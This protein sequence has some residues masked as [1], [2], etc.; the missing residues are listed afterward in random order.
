MRKWIQLLW[1]LGVTATAFSAGKVYLV[2]GSDTGIWGGAGINTFSNTYNP[3]LYLDPDDNAYGIMDPVFR[4]EIR[5]SRGQR[6]K[7]TWWM[8]GGNMFRYA[9]NP[10]VPLPNTQ[11]LY[12]MK[13]YHGEAIT[14]YGDELTLHYHTWN[15]TDYDG[16]GIYWWNQTPTFAECREDFDVTLA[17]YLLEED[18]FPVSYRSG[19]HF[20]DNGWQRYLDELLP[21]SMHNAYPVKH[22]D[23]EEPIDNSGLDWS[24]ATPDFVP[25]HP[26]YENYQLPG[27]C[28]GWNLR[29]VYFKGVTDNKLETIF[30]QAEN[31]I[32]QVPC[33][34]SHLPE[35][36]F[37]DQIRQV[38]ERVHVVAA[39]HPDVEFYYMTAIEAMQAWLGTTDTTAPLVDFTAIESGDMVRLKVQVHEAIFQPNP[40]VA[41]K[42]IYETA[43]LIPCHKV[44]RF[45]WESETEFLKAELAKASMAVTDLSG[46]LTTKHLNFL[47]DDLYLDNSDP[48]FATHLGQWQLTEDAAWGTDAV[49]A[50]LVVGDSAVVSWQLPVTVPAYYALYYQPALENQDG[51]TLQVEIKQ[52]RRILVERTIE[53]ALPG[54][55]WHY[56]GTTNLDPDRSPYVVL[57][58]RNQSGG[59]ANFAP[60]VLQITA[61]VPERYLKV[62]PR[63]LTFTEVSTMDTLHYN[64]KLENHGRNELTIFEI[65]TALPEIKFAAKWPLVIAPFSDVNIDFQFYT[66][67]RGTFADSLLIVSNDQ[68]Q[69][70]QKL[71]FSA[72]VPGYFSSVDNDEPAYWEKGE[73]HT[74]VVQAFGA[75]SR[76]SYLNQLGNYAQ[77]ESTIQYSGVYTIFEIIPKTVNASNHA[78][79]ELWA[80]GLPVDSVYIDQ[81]V[82]S[83]KWVPLFTR[84]LLAKTPIAVRVINKGGYTGGGVLRADAI[85]IQTQSGGTEIISVV[86]NKKPAAPLLY[87]NYPNPFNP[88]TTI[89]YYLASETRV[90]L[91]I[92]DVLGRELQQLCDE[93]QAPGHHEREFDGIGLSSGVY[94]LSLESEGW[95]QLQKMLL[96]K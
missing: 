26:S 31:G 74:S 1:L 5:D 53:T 76:Y 47:P 28:R 73:W 36:D 19:W 2:L 14:E 95:R 27:E 58:A 56:L 91:T 11:C 54:G 39:R 87:P 75:S 20:M 16:D 89:R 79:Y 69:P 13:K 65:R 63:M 62:Q 4:D 25:F 88:S 72:V 44:G 78:C 42:D 45:T 64:L 37:L 61:L 60:D 84:R 23:F 41:M 21:F 10:N 59:V 81:N 52:A 80:D 3:G 90:R 7:F 82:G 49:I 30:Q 85:K 38:N 35:N 46:N 8:H 40:I 22:D 9:D 55:Q 48:E 96:L 29:S 68:R 67:R 70:E 83:G 24:L 93:I 18:V 77:F 66:A 6:L 12:M 86:E 17:D 92:F 15:W 32:D 71:F 57:T 43:R 94:Y 51:V 33:F 50:E 34:W